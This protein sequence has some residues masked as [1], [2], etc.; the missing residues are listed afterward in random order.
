MRCAHGQREP[1]DAP[2]WKRSQELLVECGANGHLSILSSPSYFSLSRCP[3]GERDARSE[4]PGHQ[5]GHVTWASAAGAV[6]KS[7]PLRLGGHVGFR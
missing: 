3:Q 1:E 7:L 4:H 2:C 5:A 6:R